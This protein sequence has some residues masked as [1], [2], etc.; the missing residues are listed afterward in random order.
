MP[1]LA[2]VTSAVLPERSHAAATSSAVERRP[3]RKAA[4]AMPQSAPVGAAG[5]S[6]ATVAR[7]VST[8]M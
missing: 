7:E 1:V 6:A 8:L 3:N 4:P 5:E 2:P